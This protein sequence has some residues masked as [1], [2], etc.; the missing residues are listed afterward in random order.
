M[1]A[2]FAPQPCLTLVFPFLQG[3]WL[4][5]LGCGVVEQQILNRCG[6][7]DKIGWAF[8]LGGSWGAVAAA[9]C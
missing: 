8:G 5:V 3:E 1:V 4:E 7:G 9:L 6:A 2:C